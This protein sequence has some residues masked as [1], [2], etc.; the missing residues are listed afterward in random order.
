MTALYLILLILGLG[1][2]LAD[3]FRSASPRVSLLG[4]GLAFWIAVPL[5]QTAQNL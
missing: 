2:F 4:L 5:L 1:C 3:A